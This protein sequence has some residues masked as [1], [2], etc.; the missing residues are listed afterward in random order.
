MSQQLPPLPIVT[1]G[2]RKKQ[3]VLVD[4]GTLFGIERFNKFGVFALA[5]DPQDP[6][7]PEAIAGYVFHEELVYE[8]IKRH[9]SRMQQLIALPVDEKDLLPRFKPVCSWLYGPSQ[10]GKSTVVE[11]FHNRLNYPCRVLNGSDAIE[12]CDLI[13]KT[14]LIDGNTIAVDGVLVEAAT[15]GATLI[16]NEA[17]AIDPSVFVGLHDVFSEGITT[18]PSTGQQIRARPGFAVWVCDNTNGSG[19]TT[20]MFVGTKIQN[21][22]FMERFLA[23]EVTYPPRA[24]E[25]AIIKVHVPD[26]TDEALAVMSNIVE[27]TRDAAAGRTSVRLSKA[28]STGAF[29]KWASEFVADSAAVEDGFDPRAADGSQDKHWA[30]KHSLKEAYLRKVDPASQQAVTDILGLHIR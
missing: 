18:N 3:V 14:E 5:P 21:G 25:Q 13:S 24:A 7:I 6:W 16:V 27:A 28:I 9:N 20:G 29:I 4:A 23:S 22:A 1:I 2:G 30:F 15:L 26:I 11:Q 19:D 10:C 17:S 12:A 8:L